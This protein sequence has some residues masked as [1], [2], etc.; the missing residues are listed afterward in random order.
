[1]AR[2]APTELPPLN[3]PVIIPCLFLNGIDAVLEAEVVRLVGW[4]TMP[5][6]GGETE[7]RRIAIRAVITPSTARKLSIDLRRLTT[8][9]H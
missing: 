4:A 1:M 9:G 6:L 2:R 8:T 7:E 3:E 5:A